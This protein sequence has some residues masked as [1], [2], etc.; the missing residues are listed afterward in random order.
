MYCLLNINDVIIDIVVVVIININSNNILPISGMA[1]DVGGT[2]S[3]T[4]SWLTLNAS[5]VEI[6]TKQEKLSNNSYTYGWY[7]ED[8][9][10]ENFASISERLSNVHYS[11]QALVC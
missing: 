2:L 5:N 8:C 6:P 3:A 4:I 10:E 11:S 1:S 7:C 9:G